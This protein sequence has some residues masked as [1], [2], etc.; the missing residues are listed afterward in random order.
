MSI[1][2]PFVWNL[3]LTKLA[4]PEY[5]IIASDSSKPLG[6][7]DGAAQGQYVLHGFRPRKV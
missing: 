5:A 7:P 6:N 3:T 4:F 1:T 2:N